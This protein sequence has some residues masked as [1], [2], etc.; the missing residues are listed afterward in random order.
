MSAI[1]D[2]VLYLKKHR[3]NSLMLNNFFKIFMLILIAIASTFTLSYTFVNKKASND[4][5]IN[6]SVSL[7][8][9]LN[10]TEL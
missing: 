6:N 7:E 8:R 9:I 3:F 10:L 2:T 4:M 5:S 1:K